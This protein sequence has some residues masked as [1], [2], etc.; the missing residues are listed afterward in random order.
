MPYRIV[1][2]TYIRNIN[3]IVPINVLTKL[4]TLELE[5][6]LLSCCCTHEEVVLLWN[7]VVDSSLVTKHFEYTS[8]LEQVV[9]LHRNYIQPEVKHE[10]VIQRLIPKTVPN[11]VLIE[12]K[13]VLPAMAHSA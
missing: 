10:P 13:Q 12:S 3:P 5:E 8:V 6:V 2:M 11:Q 7:R 1:L 4:S 9:Y